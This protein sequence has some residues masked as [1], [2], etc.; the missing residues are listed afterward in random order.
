MC[1]DAFA[2]FNLLQAWA[3]LGRGGVGVAV[4]NIV[5]GQRCAAQ[6]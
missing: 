3:T 2:A 1:R 4:A 6:R 5:S